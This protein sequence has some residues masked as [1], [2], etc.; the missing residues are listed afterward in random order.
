MTVVNTLILMVFPAIMIVAAVMDMFTMTIPNRI[1]L[2]LIGFFIILVPFT[3]LGLTEIGMHVLAG[4]LMLAITFLM[5]TFMGGIGGGDAKL[6]AATGLWIGMNETLFM[7]ALYASIF[8]GLLTI[9]LMMMNKLPAPAFLV[10]HEWFARLHE[11]KSGVPYGI[12]LAAGG[13]AVFPD[14][15][16]MRAIGV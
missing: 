12:A 7:Y 9:A 14:T 11:L 2:A 16:W 15:I 10:K 6:A 3:G 8:G 5:Y 4:V 13:L 1:I